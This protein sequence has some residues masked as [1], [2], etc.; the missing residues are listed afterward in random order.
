MHLERREGGAEEGA[1]AVPAS[2]LPLLLYEKLREV[3]QDFREVSK[4]FGSDAIRVVTH[5][6]GTGPFAD[7]DRRVKD[8]YVAPPDKPGG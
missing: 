5:A 1:G 4:L 8:R 7:R 2:D 6:H 3:N